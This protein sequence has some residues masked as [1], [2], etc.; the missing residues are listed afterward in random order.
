MISFEGPETGA[1]FSTSLI[2]ICTILISVAQ[3]SL[4]H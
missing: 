4:N 3:C 1:T 2:L